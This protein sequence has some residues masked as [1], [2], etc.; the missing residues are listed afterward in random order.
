MSFK[1]YD[2]AERAEAEAN[3]PTL[4]PWKD[5]PKDERKELSRNWLALPTGTGEWKK[6]CENCGREFRALEM[7]RRLCS[8]CHWRKCYGGGY[9]TERFQLLARRGYGSYGSDRRDEWKTRVHEIVCPRC[10]GR[11]WHKEYRF[12]ALPKGAE[13]DGRRHGWHWYEHCAAGC[14]YVTAWE[15]CAEEGGAE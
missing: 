6:W 1:V 7:S 3:A 12:K 5:K 14:G 2:E 4:P 11:A 13:P 9:V 10:G 15:P 8:A